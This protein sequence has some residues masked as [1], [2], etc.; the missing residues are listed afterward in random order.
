[1]STPGIGTTSRKKRTCQCAHV[2][3]ST[4]RRQVEKAGLLFLQKFAKSNT[5]FAGIC[6]LRFD[7]CFEGTI[8]SLPQLNVLTYMSDGTMKY[9]SLLSIKYMYFELGSL[10]PSSKYRIERSEE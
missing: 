3:Y 7:A 10:P 8:I 5:S 9:S 1:M 2:K 4:E 6:I